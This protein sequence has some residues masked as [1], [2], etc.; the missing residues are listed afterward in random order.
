MMT[1]DNFRRVV[2]NASVEYLF[3]PNY[4]KVSKIEKEEFKKFLYGC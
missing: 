1:S 4:A 2:Q 3:L